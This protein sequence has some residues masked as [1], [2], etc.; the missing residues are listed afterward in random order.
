MVMERLGLRLALRLMAPEIAMSLGLQALVPQFISSQV[1]SLG[2]FG[3]T[4]PPM[5]KL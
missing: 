4:P 1:M 5:M 3:K 2:T